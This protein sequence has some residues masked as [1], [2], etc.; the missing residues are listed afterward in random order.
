[1]FRVLGIYV[2]RVARFFENQQYDK[3][4]ILSNLH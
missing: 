1:M 3:L 4:K 2:I